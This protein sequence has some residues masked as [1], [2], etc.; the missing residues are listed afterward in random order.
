MIQRPGRTHRCAP[1]NWFEL[2][3]IRLKM[4]VGANPCV[5]PLNRR[6]FHV[7]LLIGQKRFGQRPRAHTRVR[8]YAI[9]EKC[10]SLTELVEIDF[11]GFDT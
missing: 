10:G 8:P 11:R 2:F 9:K 7:R 4:V 6:Y 1:T 3:I 5:R